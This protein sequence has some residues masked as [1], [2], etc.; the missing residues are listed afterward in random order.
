MED[1]INPPL[2]KHLY[3]FIN[4][5]RVASYKTS[6]RNIQPEMRP[7]TFNNQVFYNQP[8][9]L[10]LITKLKPSDIT[11][12][13]LSRTGSKKKGP[14]TNSHLLKVPNSIQPVQG[15][16]LFISLFH[17]QLPEDTTKLYTPDY[18]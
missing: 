9:R 4:Q 17:N 8:Y 6:S 14:L 16:G 18:Y 7:T 11:Q 15:S 10:I 12:R 3:V 2:L 5:S 1:R 13:P